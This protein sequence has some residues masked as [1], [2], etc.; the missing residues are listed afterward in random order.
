MKALDEYPL[1]FVYACTASINLQQEKLK[2]NEAL[3]K[4]SLWKQFGAA[5][6]MLENAIKLCPENLWDNKTKFW[7]NAFHCLFYLDYYLSLEPANFSPPPPFG[8]TEFDPGGAMPE[9]TYTKEEVLSYLQWNRDKCR[10]LIAGLTGELATSRWVN[11][12]KN[13][14]VYEIL[15]YNLRHVQHHAA[16]LNQLL[17]QN[18]NDAPKWVAQTKNGL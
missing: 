4:E 16:Q 14:S 5:I 7:H 3:L 13:Y 10:N 15:L 8:L 6:D 18:I 9:R 1:I 2:M 12:Y 11:E 17:R